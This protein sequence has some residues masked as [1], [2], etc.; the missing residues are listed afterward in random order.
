M[1][2]Q[3]VFEPIFVGIHCRR[4]LFISDIC[5]LWPF[6]FEGE[7]TNLVRA[8]LTAT[9][10]GN[11]IGG[12]SV[13][14]GRRCYSKGCYIKTSK[15]TICALLQ[16]NMNFPGTISRAHS[17]L[18]SSQQL[19]TRIGWGKPLQWRQKNFGQTTCISLPT[20]SRPLASKRPELVK[21]WHFWASVTILSSR[22]VFSKIWDSCQLLSTCQASTF[23]QWGA[24][25]AGGKVHK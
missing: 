5:E 12:R 20:C 1:C 6:D 23:G 18:F 17:G 3:T 10:M 21:T 8:N 2:W 9:L 22:W 11:T 4:A 19:T 16:Q 25:L 24:L 14:T 15:E 7:L 13:C